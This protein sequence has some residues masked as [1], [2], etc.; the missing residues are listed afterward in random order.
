MHICE[1][2][3]I[4]FQGYDGTQ[5]TRC[6][7]CDASKTVPAMVIKKSGSPENEPDLQIVYRHE[8]EAAS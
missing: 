2:E 5:R 1:C 7:N 3:A 4:I 6:P 8:A